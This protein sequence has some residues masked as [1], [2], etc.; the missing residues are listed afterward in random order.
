VDP[1]KSTHALFGQRK[2]WI[3]GSFFAFEKVKREIAR[4]NRCEFCLHIQIA[5]LSFMNMLAFVAPALFMFTVSVAMQAFRADVLTK[6]FAD[7]IP[8]N[9][10]IYNAFVLVMNFIYALLWLGFILY[11]IHMNNKNPKF[12]SYIYA[13]STIMGI[14]SLVVMVVLTVDIIRGL[15]GDSSCNYLFKP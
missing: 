8:Y 13:T 5:F 15:I 4:G 6:F 1:I 12:I 11:S 14:F 3:N 7:I 2:R 9:S 10:E